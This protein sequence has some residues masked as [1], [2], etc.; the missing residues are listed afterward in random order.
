MINKPKLSLW[1]VHPHCAIPYQRHMEIAKGDLDQTEGK[2]QS[3]TSRFLHPFP[4]PNVVLPEVGGLKEKVPCPLTQTNQSH[5]QGCRSNAVSLGS[6]GPQNAQDPGSSYWIQAS[7]RQ[8]PMWVPCVNMQQGTPVSDI[9]WGAEHW[10]ET[11]IS[12]V[13]TTHIHTHTHHSH[14]YTPFTYIHMHACA[15]PPHTHT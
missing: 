1:G 5:R 7:R 9:L 6:H 13:V 4:M 11:Q 15:C 12:G 8:K 2:F 14:I 3:H 10:M